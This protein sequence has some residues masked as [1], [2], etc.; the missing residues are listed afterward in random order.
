[1]EKG[2]RR[3]PTLRPFVFLP[4]LQGTCSTSSCQVKP[5][6]SCH[7][8]QSPGISLPRV[9]VGPCMIAGCRGLGK[10]RQADKE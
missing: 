1:M 7:V 3:G 10:A 6:S 9:R 5:F 8:H 2:T 4:H